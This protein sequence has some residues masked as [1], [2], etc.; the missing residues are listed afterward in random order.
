MNRYP[1]LYTFRRC[2]YA[3]RARLALAYAKVDIHQEEV[4]LKNKPLEMIKASAK[5]TVPVLILEDGC[6]ID[7][8]IDIIMWA[9]TQSDP[10]GWLSTELKGTCDDLINSNDTQFKPILDGYKYSQCSE[11]KNSEYYREKANTFF[12]QLN[13]LLMKNHYLLADHINFADILQEWGKCDQD[14]LFMS[15]I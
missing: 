2:P 3:I 4:D 7:E 9:L 1:L 15:L 11:K 12:N 13:T 14:H 6:V 5:A 8:S 10:D